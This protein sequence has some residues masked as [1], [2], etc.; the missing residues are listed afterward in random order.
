MNRFF[1]G[2][3]RVFEPLQLFSEKKSDNGETGIRQIKAPALIII[4]SELLTPLELGDRP[5]QSWVN[6]GKNLRFADLLDTKY[7]GIGKQSV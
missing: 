3:V 2:F 5:R 4:Q 1:F 7:K 6:F